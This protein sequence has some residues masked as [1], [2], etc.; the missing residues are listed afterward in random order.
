MKPTLAFALGP[1]KTTTFQ[2]CREA[3]CRNHIRHSLGQTSEPHGLCP[4]NPLC[5]LCPGRVERPELSPEIGRRLSSSHADVHQHL[6]WAQ[7]SG[8]IVHMH[9]RLNPCCTPYSSILSTDTPSKFL[10]SNEN[11]TA[12][13]R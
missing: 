6:P 2:C 5:S 4:T 9:L 7:L 8:G 13:A 3:K 11:G 10:R 12:V 1:V